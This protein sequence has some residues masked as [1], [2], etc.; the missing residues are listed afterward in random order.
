MPYGV[1]GLTIST[2][3]LMEIPRLLFIHFFWFGSHSTALQGR[4]QLDGSSACFFA[5][6]YGLFMVGSAMMNCWMI[7]ALLLPALLTTIAQF[8]TSYS[9]VRE[10]CYKELYPMT[11]K[12]M[13]FQAKLNQNVQPMY[14]LSDDPVNCHPP[15]QEIVSRPA[16]PNLRTLRSVTGIC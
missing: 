13:M 15:K 4:H 11:S 6:L 14:F 9:F 2:L 7:F 10:T 3:T 5:V 16:W 1:C 12:Q 8:M